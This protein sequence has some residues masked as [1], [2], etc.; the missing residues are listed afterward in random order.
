VAPEIEKA[1]GSVSP[2]AGDRLGTKEPTPSGCSFDRRHLGCS[3]CRSSSRGNGGGGPRGVLRVSA[4]YAGRF[5]HRAFET[6]AQAVATPVAAASEHRDRRCP[7][8]SGWGE[9][10]GASDRDGRCRAHEGGPPSV[11]PLARDISAGSA[12]RGHPRSVPLPQGSG[13]KNS[14][15]PGRPRAWCAGFVRSSG[16]ARGSWSGCRSRQAVC[17]P[18]RHGAKSFLSGAGSSCSRR[19]PRAV[20][21]HRELG[22]ARQSRDTSG[23]FPTKQAPRERSRGAPVGGRRSGVE[24]AVLVDEG[25]VGTILGVVSDARSG[26][27]SALHDRS[28]GGL[29]FASCAVDNATARWCSFGSTPR[30]IRDG[31]VGRETTGRSWRGAVTCS[32]TRGRIAVRRSGVATKGSSGLVVAVYGGVSRRD[33]RTER[34]RGCS[35]SE[36][37]AEVGEKHL[38]LPTRQA[39]RRAEPGGGSRARRPACDEAKPTGSG[40]RVLGEARERHREREEPPRAKGAERCLASEDRPDG[41]RPGP[42]GR[43]ALTGAAAGGEPSKG[44]SLPSDRSWQRREAH[45]W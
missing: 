14:C 34:V 42:R 33:S 12:R 21:A 32:S 7:S 35:C 10:P 20:K 6:E 36:S 16:R 5:R 8:R 27:R 4:G 11:R 2:Q 41:R 19:E 45:A 23:G 38:P 40:E 22:L 3:G 30:A 18:S 13:S 26:E 37:V 15:A 25:A 17:G 1:R 44:G 39:A 24:E 31:W 43:R 9:A 28:V 29:R